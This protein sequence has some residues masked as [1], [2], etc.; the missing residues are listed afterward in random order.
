MSPRPKEE[1]FPSHRV[2]HTQ[3]LGLGVEEPPADPGQA[4][5]EQEQLQHQCG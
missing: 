3:A 4:G 1:G 2:K 5:Q